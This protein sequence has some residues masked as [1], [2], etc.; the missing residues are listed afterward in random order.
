LLAGGRKQTTV[1]EAASP[2]AGFGSGGAGEDAVTAHPTQ[3]PL[4]LFERP[5]LNH[6][7]PSEIVY[8]PFAGSGTC[9]IGAARHGRR[10]LAV[11]LDP[12]WCDVIRDRYQHYLQ[13]GG[14]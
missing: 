3:K 12:S 8:D 2:I 11:E 14:S 7:R 4:E 6:T 10:C 1:W 13:A 9:L 5:I